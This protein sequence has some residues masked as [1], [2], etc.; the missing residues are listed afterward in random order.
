MFINLQHVSSS[1]SKC[2]RGQSALGNQ[3]YWDPQKE[4]HFN[5]YDRLIPTMM[6]NSIAIHYIHMRGIQ[7]L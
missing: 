1:N 7:D 3:A 2:T 6:E 5:H 4:L